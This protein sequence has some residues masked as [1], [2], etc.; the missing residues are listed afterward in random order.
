MAYFKIG[1]TDFSDFVSALKCNYE[2]LLSS[3]SGRNAAGDNVIDIVNRKWKLEVSFIPMTDTQMQA[4]MSA[5][6]DFVVSVQFLNPITKS[7]STITA[8]T[9]TPALDYYRIKTDETIFKPFSLSFIQ[10]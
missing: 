6:S 10:M 8:Y 4:F 1:S 3:D 5:I 7:L 2:T 9:G